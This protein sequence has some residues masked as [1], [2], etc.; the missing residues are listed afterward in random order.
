MCSFEL[1]TFSG[2]RI[3]LPP[4]S[5]GRLVLIRTLNKYL[6]TEELDYEKLKGSLSMQGK[7]IAPKEKTE[8]QRP[9]KTIRRP[10]K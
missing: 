4:E 1:G 9:L 2:L 7:E 6:E 8:P 10:S 3:T 5:S